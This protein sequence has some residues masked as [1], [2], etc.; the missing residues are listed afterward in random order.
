AVQP[1]TAAAQ[2]YLIDVAMRLVEQD[3]S[4]NR[5]TDYRRLRSAIEIG[6]V[7]GRNEQIDDLHEAIVLRRY[8]RGFPG[9]LVKIGNNFAN[10]IVGVDALDPVP[11][12]G[13]HWRREIGLP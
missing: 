2:Q 10:R 13:Q 11:E 5:T 8:E 7:L 6:E 1:E 3:R 12:A 4:S 9:F